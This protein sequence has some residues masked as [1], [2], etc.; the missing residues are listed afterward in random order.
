M[1]QI[2][3]PWQKRQNMFIRP[4]RKVENGKIFEKKL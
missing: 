2:L 3:R 4:G 1:R